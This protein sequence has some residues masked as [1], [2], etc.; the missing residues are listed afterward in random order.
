MKDFEAIKIEFKP[1]VRQKMLWRN[2]HKLAARSP[3]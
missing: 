2:G 3:E 1:E